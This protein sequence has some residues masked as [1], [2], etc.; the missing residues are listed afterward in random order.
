MEIFI[1]L[2][3]Q[4]PGI[5]D[6]SAFDTFGVPAILIAVIVVVGVLFFRGVIRLGT[7]CDLLLDAEKEKTEAAKVEA[8][9]AREDL[10]RVADDFN[11]NFKLVITELTTSNKE[12]RDA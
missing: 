6:L 5:E 1:L 8:R 9:A 2:L 4:V 11:A 7:T 3:L 10:T 12:R